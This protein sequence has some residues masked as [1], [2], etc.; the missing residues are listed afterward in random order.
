M[1]ISFAQAAG[2]EDLSPD[3]H[4][5]YDAVLTG[6]KVQR[7]L[8]SPDAGY[9]T[10]VRARRSL[11]LAVRRISLLDIGLNAK[12]PGMATQAVIGGGDR[13]IA[14]SSGQCTA[15]LQYNLGQ[16]GGCL[17]LPQI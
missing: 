4:Q 17:L 5:N 10:V 15:L 8:L 6:V 3:W 16:G 9:E 12:E 11:G 1:V 2:C 13:R 14:D 7:P